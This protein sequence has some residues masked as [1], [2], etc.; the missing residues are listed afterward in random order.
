MT[1]LNTLIEV[2]N[3][4]L[5]EKTAAIFMVVARNNFIDSAA[6]REKLPKIAP[7]SVNSNIGVLIKKGFIEKSGDGLILTGNGEQLMLDTAQKF[8]EENNPELLKERKSRK[9][10][11]GED[12]LSEQDW[13]VQVVEDNYGL[14]KPPIEY[15]SNIIIELGDRKLG[16]KTFEIKN[17]MKA[18]RMVYSKKINKDTLDQLLA[19]GM[20]D[21]PKTNGTGGYLD[22]EYSH[23]F[24]EQVV[25]IIN[26][27]RVVEESK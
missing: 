24:I 19:L 20:T 13:M 7:N 14:N 1:K 12:M 10:E 6:I 8:A 17:K 4:V 9:R 23:E 15:R 25:K 26:S 21:K 3:N 27:N 16:I 11:I 5:N 22:H 18:F 2:S